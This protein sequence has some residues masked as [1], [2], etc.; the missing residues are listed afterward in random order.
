M[1]SMSASHPTVPISGGTLRLSFFVLA[2]LLLKS[3]LARFL[4]L[5]DVDPVRGVIREAPILVTG[6]FMALL[7]PDRT[8]KLGLLAMDAFFSL[9]MFAIT[10]YEAYYGQIPTASVLDLLGQAIPVR[11]SVRALLEPLH[12]LFAADLVLL[13]AASLI[14]RTRQ[15]PPR[16]VGTRLFSWLPRHRLAWIALMLAGSGSIAGFITLLVLRLTHPIDARAASHERGLL[17]FQAAALLGAGRS[18]W[19]GTARMD[20]VALSSLIK[21]LQGEGKEP[22]IAG[23]MSRSC[24]GKNLIL[25]QVESLQTAVVGAKIAGQEVTPNLNRFLDECWYFPNTI[26]QTGHGTT[27][28]AEFVV[29][30]SLY[31]STTAASSVKYGQRVLPSLPR[32]LGEAGYRTFTFHTNWVGFWRRSSLYAALGFSRYYDRDFFGDEDRIAFGASDEVLYRK[33]FMELLD[34][35]DS[36]RPFYAQVITMSSHHPFDHIPADRL[37][38]AL[39]PPFHGTYTGRYLASMEYADRA[40]GGFLAELRRVGLLDESILAVYGDH[41]GLMD[42]RQP[43]GEVAAQ[44]ALLGRPYTPLDRMRVPLIIRIP[45]HTTGRTL[46]TPASQLDILP[47]VA[48][49]MGIDLASHPHFGRNLFHPGS[50]LIRASG[51]QPLG[52]YVDEDLFYVSGASFENG[53]CFSLAEPHRELPLGRASRSKRESIL[54]LTRVSEDYLA[55]LPEREPRHGSP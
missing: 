29:N 16:R 17:V 46:D 51:F 36:G 43:R 11:G 44:R 2:A 28:D 3:L 33:T 47:T 55:S 45:G 54:R 8:R 10:L 23:F 19:R 39:P 4:V 42:Q 30:T 5:G 6:V 52:S 40:L 7:L 9:V 14:G 1:S 31:P 32:S 12:L 13:P 38:L 35:R 48:D 22:R 25:I 27:A 41:A 37:G 21:D 20:P 15:E 49:L 24:E 34:H 50:P 53:Q 18:E 26:S